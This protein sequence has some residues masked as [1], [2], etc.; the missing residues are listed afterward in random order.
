MVCWC[1]KGR[2]DYDFLP[3]FLK[4]NMPARRTTTTAAVTS[5]P[6]PSQGS[7]LDSA[8]TDAVAEL[9]SEPTLLTFVVVEGV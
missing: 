7:T 5:K 4:A 8:A 1:A 9:D 2:G 3:Y 6:I